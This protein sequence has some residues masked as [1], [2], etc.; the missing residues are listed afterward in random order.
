MC[1]TEDGGG[2]TLNT[3]TH[4]AQYHSARD[5]SSGGSSGNR[6]KDLRISHALAARDMTETVQ[7]LYPRFD[8]YLLSKCEAADQ[9]GVEIR[10]DALKRLYMIYAPTEWKK[11]QRRHTD[12]HRRQRCIRCRLDEAIYQELVTLIH[13][14]GFDTVQDWLESQVN[15]F[16]AMRRRRCE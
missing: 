7:N 16:V 9:Y 5:L 3:I 6:L 13:E 1:K 11:I 2:E 10:E 4:E 8:R 15:V 14:D 12:R